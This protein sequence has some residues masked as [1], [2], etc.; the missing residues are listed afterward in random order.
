[1]KYSLP[2]R[3]HRQLQLNKIRQPKKK[4]KRRIPRFLQK[5][6]PIPA[7]FARR[8]VSDLSFH[9]EFSGNDI[10]TSETFLYGKKMHTIKANNTEEM[11]SPNWC[12]KLTR[13]MIIVKLVHQINYDQFCSFLG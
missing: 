5:F 8:T 9:N 3:A 1:M 11:I 10:F 12:E 6:H 7:L 13:T 2:P 4:N